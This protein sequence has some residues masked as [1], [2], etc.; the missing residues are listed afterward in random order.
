LVNTSVDGVDGIPAAL[1]FGPDGALYATD[2]GRRAI[3]RIDTNGEMENFITHWDEMR[4]NGPNDLSFD[5]SGYLYFTDP[6]TSGPTNPIGGVYEYAWDSGTLSQMDSGLQFPNGIIAR[7]DRLYVAETYTRLVWLHDISRRQ[8]QGRKH[9]FA[10]LPE[11]PTSRIQGPDGMA[12]D[13]EGN[14]LVTHVGSGEI[15]VYS[16]EGDLLERIPT[17]GAMPTNVCFVGED[18][19]S[20]AVT[21]DDLGLLVTI[22][23]GMKGERLFYCPSTDPQSDW[24]G[25]LESAPRVADV[26]RT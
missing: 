3:V 7:G 15:F 6:W 26:P 4:L 20:I 21:V 12:C 13:E 25:V 11:V 1:A 8:G 9:K 14:V 22:P 2:E 23:Y 24:L 18:L 19:D 17:G 5:G 16:P 10:E